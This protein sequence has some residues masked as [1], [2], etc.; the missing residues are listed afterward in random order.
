M[1]IDVYIAAARTPP[2]S[3]PANN[4]LRLPRAIPLSAL[5][6]ALLVRQMPRAL[7]RLRT[8]LAG[9]DDGDRQFVTVLTAVLEDGLE[10]VEAACAEALDCGACSA[11]VVLN[12]LARLRQPAPAADIP[13]P[14][15][16]QL[17]HQPV[18]DCQRYDS[19]READH[20]A[21]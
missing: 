12:I 7:G 19:L 3:E 13:T 17:R 21:P 10:A 5:S 2:R 15:S 1:P 20:G 4:Q 14:E 9:H 11:D 16:L 6:A 18:A 8:R